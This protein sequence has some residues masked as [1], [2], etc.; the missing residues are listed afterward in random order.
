M[1]DRRHT[2]NDR[3]PRKHGTGTR[4]GAPQGGRP[5]WQ[6][7]YVERRE[8]RRGYVGVTAQTVPARFTGHCTDAKRDGGRRGRPGTLTHALREVIRSG[9]DP[10][11]A[12]RVVALARVDDPNKARQAEANWIRALNTA[13]PNGFNVMPGGA[14]LGGPFNAK[15]VKV[16]HPTRGLL[17]FPALSEAI[18]LREQELRTARRPIPNARSIYYRV[19]AGWPLEQALGYQPH[20]DRR[21][22][23]R[24]LYRGGRRYASRDAAAM[25][26]ITPGALRS[27]RHR[28]DR[29]GL[30]RGS[31]GVDRR[32]RG[33][34]RAP[35]RPV[36]LPDPRDPAA[37]PL[38]T[39]DFAAASGIPK[40]TVIH[41]LTRLRL[42]GRDP[43]MMPRAE[44]L[45]V[46]AHRVER[47]V[48]IE[49]PVPGG[50]VLR[51]GARELVRTV[52]RDRVLRLER[53]HQL[54]D[55]AIRA[56]LRLLPG[57][58]E[59]LPL[60]PHQVRW[61]FGFVPGAMPGRAAD[62]PITR[63]ASGPSTEP[64]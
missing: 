32:L 12:F 34:R 21:G 60:D 17:K 54:G 22:L 26:G 35:R 61:A 11:A 58:R 2:T 14:S 43:A 30:G 41:R 4:R 42:A 5:C 23:R 15:P 55:S 40:A 39:T 63:N 36:L 38:N 62:H 28:A 50:Q 53:P 57:W 24:P 6:I 47:R 29:A 51:G 59:R 13:Q 33:A 3:R 49:L 44:V 31:L 7:Y 48:M 1:G 9:Q 56:R 25:I 10:A 19:A 16:E 18:G 37:P 46:L 45:A 64:A 20:V 52:L 27:R 8:D